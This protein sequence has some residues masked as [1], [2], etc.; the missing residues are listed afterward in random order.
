M[1][2]KKDIQLELER[3]EKRKSP[4]RKEA[5]YKILNQGLSIERSRR[6]DSWKMICSAW[7]F[8]RRPNVSTRNSPND[9]ERKSN[10]EVNGQKKN[11]G[12]GR[13]SL[14]SMIYGCYNVQ[15]DRDD[16]NRDEENG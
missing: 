5:C 14:C 10:K 3:K 2:L 7:L 13:E 8:K 1:P 16:I 6:N 9:C 15:N 12:R 4:E 11:H